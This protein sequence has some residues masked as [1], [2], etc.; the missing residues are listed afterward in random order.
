MVF[1]AL[2]VGAYGSPIRPFVMEAMEVREEE[3]SIT[4]PLSLR[5]LRRVGNHERE[6]VTTEDNLKEVRSSST[7]FGAVARP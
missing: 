3:T 1:M 6:P 4:P 7:R 5:I 2:C